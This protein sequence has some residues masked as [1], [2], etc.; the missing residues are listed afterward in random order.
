[1][2]LV[3]AGLAQ[4]PHRRTA[5]HPIGVLIAQCGHRLMVI[6]TLHDAPNGKRCDQCTAAKNLSHHFRVRCVIDSRRWFVR[7]TSIIT[8]A[9]ES[10][11]LPV[12]FG[13]AF[14]KHVATMP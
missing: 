3:R 10:S 2:G 5:D 11:T 1:M 8:I 9:H 7:S 14:A 4:S 12:S 6:T 13:K